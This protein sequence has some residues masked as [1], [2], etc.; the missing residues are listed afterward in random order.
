MFIPSESRVAIMQYLF[1]EGVVVAKNDLR[2]KTHPHIQG[3]KN[4]HVVK[5]LQGFASRGLVKQ[6]YAWRHYYWFLT[7]PGVNFLREYLHLPATVVPATHKQTGKKVTIINERPKRQFKAGE[8]PQYRTDRKTAPTKTEGEQ[9][10]VAQ[11]VPQGT[12]TEKPKT[13]G[14][15]KGFQQ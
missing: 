3:V 5:F 7:G 11:T 4:L 6:Q 1:K 8:K 2:L 15:G 14:R 10:P 12:T 13:G 9:Q